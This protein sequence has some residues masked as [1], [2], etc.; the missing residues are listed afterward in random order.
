MQVA[1]RH[2]LPVLVVVPVVILRSRPLLV[3]WHHLDGAYH[4]ARTDIGMVSRH[5]RIVLL[6]VELDGIAI[7]FPEL[8]IT[9]EAQVALVVLL[10]VAV[11]RYGHHPSDNSYVTLQGIGADLQGTRL[12]RRHI[13][14]VRSRQIDE[15]IVG[16]FNQSLYT[17][18]YRQDGSQWQEYIVVHVRSLHRLD[19]SQV[20]H[21]CLP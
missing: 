10:I 1:F 18:S 17:I 20:V 9:D 21:P 13:G 4:I 12:S 8:E 16:F 3:F 11:G 15:F 2:T 5:S 6:E 14:V 7:A 19:G